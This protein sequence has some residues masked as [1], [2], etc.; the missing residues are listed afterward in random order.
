MLS[1][2]G[3]LLL[4][5]NLVTQEQLDEALEH[6]RQHGGRLGEVLS[7][8]GYITDD[9]LTRTVAM[10][11]GV[12]TVNLDRLE[13]EREVLD[14]IPA[15]MAR[16]FRIIPISRVGS[17]LTC[18]MQDPTSLDIINRVEFQT[19]CN[20]QPVLVTA[21]MMTAA[22]ER[23]YPSPT[24]THSSPAIEKRAAR[25]AL[26]TELA[27]RLEKLSMDKLQYVRRFLDSIQ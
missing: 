10:R 3:Q 19:G 1:K 14:I 4:W 12:P 11:Y 23:F 27:A 21:A 15:E 17:T 2:F 13:V 9:E 16:N 25:T 24:P 26:V 18:A 7:H 20:L 22:L 6:Q 8:L 5:G